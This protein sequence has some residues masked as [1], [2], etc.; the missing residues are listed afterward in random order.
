GTGSLLPLLA[1]PTLDCALGCAA[2]RGYR[3]CDCQRVSAVATS[4]GTSLSAPASAIATRERKRGSQPSAPTAM[5]ASESGSPGRGSLRR[6]D[7]PRRR[8]PHRDGLRCRLALG[9]ARTIRTGRCLRR[10]TIFLPL[11]Q[12]VGL[13]HSRLCHVCHRH[14]Y[15]EVIGFLTPHLPHHYRRQR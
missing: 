6:L 11:R 14:D 5:V 4:T 7:R 2:S 8:G 10:G 13:T 12:S 15:P 9:D 3:G 1:L